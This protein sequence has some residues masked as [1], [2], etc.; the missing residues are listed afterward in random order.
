MLEIVYLYEKVIEGMAKKVIRLTEQDLHEIVME[1]TMAVLN[2]PFVEMRAIS[3]EMINEMA[4]IN[5]NEGGKCIFPCNKYEV[6]IWSNDHNPPHFH[7]LCD[8]WNI[9]F[10]IEDGELYRVEGKGRDKKE[11]KY[12]VNSVKTWLKSACAVQPKLTNQENAISIW[13]QLH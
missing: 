7:V 2:N 13:H 12:I 8:G 5:T 3:Q 1:S 11:Y 10:T 4:R 9:L 6:K